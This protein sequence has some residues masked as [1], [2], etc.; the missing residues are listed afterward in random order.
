MWK[1]V[2]IGLSGLLITAT[3]AIAA[4][5]QTGRWVTLP[6][7]PSTIEIDG[8][9]VDVMVGSEALEARVRTRTVHPARV[10][11]SPALASNETALRVTVPDE[12]SSDVGWIEVEVPRNRPLDLV[13]TGLRLTVTVDSPPEALDAP[14]PA[15]PP[16]SIRLGL[17][18][19]SVRIEGA[20]LLELTAER[21]TVEVSADDGGLTL[22]FRSSHAVVNGGSGPVT[23]TL[24]GGTELR[25][26]GRTGDIRVD[27]ARSGLALWRCAGQVEVRITD[28]ACEIEGHRG[29]AAAI[30]VDRGTL[31]A[32]G[33]SLP[34]A[35]LT[36]RDATASLSGLRAG[37][38]ASLEGS[39]LDLDDFWGN[40]TLTVDGR[41]RVDG[42]TVDGSVELEMRSGA[43]ASL[44]FVKGVAK[45]S[46]DDAEIELDGAQWLSIVATRSIVRASRFEGV[47]EL[48]ATDSVVELN[49]LAATQVRNLQL[50]GG[51][52]LDLKVGAPCRVKVLGLEPTVAGKL[53][54]SGCEIGYGERPRWVS[55]GLDRSGRR[56]VMVVVEV[57]P[58][59]SVTV[60]GSP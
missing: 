6:P 60:E 10:P 48:S 26:E 32:S 47:T 55:A 20:E 16:S 45:A 41:S 9:D 8:L 21:S 24:D 14:T 40:A 58:G 56:P 51:S 13:G 23:A 54:V 57:E 5:S 12:F 27:G 53:Y 52:S 19:S 44:S 17:A 50:G 42:Q 46:L 35:V 36:L 49:G 34:Q 38:S 18:N 25:L 37:V 30:T 29:G 3:C 22:S 11:P 7:A 43:T 15:I 39:S 59:S 28:G 4:G 1:T 31:R 2:W 33:S